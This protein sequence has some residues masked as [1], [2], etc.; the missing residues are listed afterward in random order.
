MPFRKRSAQAPEEEEVTEELLAAIPDIPEIPEIP[1]VAQ[2]AGAA[3]FTPVAVGPGNG[4]T[5][6]VQPRPGAR[7]EALLNGVRVEMQQMVEKE[8]V[9]MRSTVGEF[10]SQLE[11]QVELD[12]IEL[13]RL[14]EENEALRKA[15]ERYAQ[16]VNGLKQ[17]ASAT[18]ERA[19]P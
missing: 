19:E 8:M 2:P 13:R 18:G 3:A 10:L 7:F 4:V 6:P 9:R 16:T 17:L 11:R 15:N 14:R 12:A 5:R 1:A